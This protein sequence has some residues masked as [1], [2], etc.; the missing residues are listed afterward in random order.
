MSGRKKLQGTIEGTEWEQCVLCGKIMEVRKDTPV[1]ERKY[2]VEAAEKKK[3]K[4]YAEV[5]GREHNEN[6]IEL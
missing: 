6:I 3:K 5:Y 2:Y 1:G 4:C